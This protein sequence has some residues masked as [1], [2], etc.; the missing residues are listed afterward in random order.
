MALVCA[1]ESNSL[2]CFL[3]CVRHSVMRTVKKIYKLSAAKVIQANQASNL[4]AKMLSTKATSI[5]VGT[6]LYKE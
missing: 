5:R 2:A 6:M 1:A 3:K 4:M